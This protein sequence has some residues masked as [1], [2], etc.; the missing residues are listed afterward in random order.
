M[1][2]RRL[3]LV[4]ALA[5]ILFAAGGPAE[6]C[7]PVQ[8]GAEDHGCG[9]TAKGAAT[10][11][12]GVSDFSFTPG[13]VTVA[14]GDKVTWRWDDPNHTVTSDPGQSEQFESDP[15]ESSFSVSHPQG[16]TFSRTFSKTGTFAYHCRVHDFMTGKVVVKV[17]GADTEA[18]TVKSLKLSRSKICRKKTDD[19]K[20]TSA[21]LLFKLSEPADV[22]AV[23]TRP[24]KPDKAV[25]T[26]TD[27]GD[28]GSNR[29]K[30]S[31]KKLKLGK[32][33]VSVTATDAAGNESDVAKI[34]LRVKK[35]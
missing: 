11:T 21:K 8:Y 22:E 2:P 19:C 16:D 28:D 18:P 9:D 27:E 34:T 3:L 25:K 6:A 32:Y 13:S 5:L 20:K 14:P 30:L 10:K 7:H 33:R 15:G 35:G 24:A 4:P 17:P 29:L 31:S 12:V 1:R 26:L 23:V